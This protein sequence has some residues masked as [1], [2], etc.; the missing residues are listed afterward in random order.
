[1]AVNR[2]KGKASRREIGAG[3][4]PQLAS[5]QDAFIEHGFASPPRLGGARKS[6]KPMRINLRAVAEVLADEGMDPA[7]EM[8]RIM[9]EQIPLRDR[10]GMMVLDENGE[11]V[12][13]DRIE[14]EVKLRMLNEML[15]YTQPKLKAIEVTGA[16]GGPITVAS[17][18]SEQAEKIARE[19]LLATQ[20]GD[21]DE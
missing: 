7:Y 4:P 5:S 1:M 8:V 2:A 13:V 14:P 12:M 20:G 6:K 21:A 16:N 10:N 18:S 3:E 17:L 19:F 15:Q 11:P 9:K